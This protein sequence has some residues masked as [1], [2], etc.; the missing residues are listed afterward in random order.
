MKYLLILAVCITSFF[1]GNFY[2]KWQLLESGPVNLSSDLKIQSSPK[3][4]GLL[5]KGTTMY[6]Y[7]SLDTET[8]VI[9][10]NTKALDALETVHFENAMTVAPI[11]AYK[12]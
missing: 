3:N 2:H 11:D 9:F 7:S 6:P 5:P 12:P 4:I 8:Y 10:V 1:C